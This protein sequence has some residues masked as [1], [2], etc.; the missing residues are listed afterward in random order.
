MPWK[1]SKFK[2]RFKNDGPY[3]KVTYTVRVE[4]QSNIRMK[5]GLCA[6][7]IDK[8]DFEIEAIPG[9]SLNFAPGKTDSTSDRFHLKPDLWS[10]VAKIK[11]YIGPYR[12]ADS[13]SEAVSNIVIIT[14]NSH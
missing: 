14:V 2:V 1:L 9:Q 6:R 4:N 13:P 3:S 7:L 10:E 11:A 8:D 12:C 5:G